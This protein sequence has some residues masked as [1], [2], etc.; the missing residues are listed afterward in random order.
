MNSPWFKKNLALDNMSKEDLMEKIRGRKD[1]G[2]SGSDSG[3]DNPLGDL[4]DP[5]FCGEFEVEYSKY[6]KQHEGLKG[7]NNTLYDQVTNIVNKV[8]NYCSDGKLSFIEKLELQ[9]YA[10]LFQ[11]FFDFEEVEIEVETI[12]PD[13]SGNSSENIDSF[14]DD[15]DDDG[16]VYF[17]YDD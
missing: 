5:N 4:G 15:D 14:D 9:A 13:T 3:D 17:D 12:I 16:D 6:K 1:N 8:R 2:G 11:A 7:V 10:T